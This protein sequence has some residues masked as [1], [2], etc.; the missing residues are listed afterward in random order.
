[1][2]TVTAGSRTG[3]SIIEARTRAALA[4]LLPAAVAERAWP[5]HL[6]DR[7]AASA[8][9]VLAALPDARWHD[10]VS[11][12]H[13]DFEDLFTQDWRSL[14]D[15]LMIRIAAALYGAPG[16]NPSVADLP[17]L[18]VPGYFA[19]VVDA[20]RIARAGFDVEAVAS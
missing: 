13:I 12:V 9:R 20:V 14:N 18:E 6:Y 17:G 7:T 5:E 16:A 2:T 8:L 19:A 1:M 4:A 3:N 15:R 10:A 11:P